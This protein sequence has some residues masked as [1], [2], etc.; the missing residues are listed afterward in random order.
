MHHGCAERTNNIIK[1]QVHVF[2]K[3]RARPSPVEIAP[4]ASVRNTERAP[5]AKRVSEWSRSVFFF[6]HLERQQNAAHTTHT[7]ASECVRGAQTWQQHLETALFFSCSVHA[8]FFFVPLRLGLA[9]VVAVAE[10]SFPAAAAC[11]NP[12]TSRRGAERQPFHFLFAN[13]AGLGGLLE[14]HLCRVHKQFFNWPPPSV[15][16]VLKLATTVCCCC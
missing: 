13:A 4:S 3:T 11:N 15:V 9:V 12:G 16:V 5:P 7:R 8:F 2:L 1:T 14:K 6:F 10:R